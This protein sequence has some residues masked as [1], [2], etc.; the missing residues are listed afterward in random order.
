M[1]PKQQIKRQLQ[2]LDSS[3]KIVTGIENIDQYLKGGMSRDIMI[4]PGTIN[5]GKT[6][7]PHQSIK[8]L[9]HNKSTDKNG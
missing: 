8:A 9:I 3:S 4:L 1:T 5:S 6:Y 2:N 7:W